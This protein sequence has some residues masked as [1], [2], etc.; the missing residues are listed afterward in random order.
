M[1][2]YPAPDPGPEPTATEEPF[3]CIQCARTHRF[4]FGHTV[5][6]A[7][8]SRD[9]QDGWRA[10]H[11]EPT[12]NKDPSAWGSFGLGP[13]P[14]SL[15]QEATANKDSS[16][17]HSK[18]F[19]CGDMCLTSRLYHREGH[20][21]CSES[22]SYAWGGDSDDATSRG[23]ASP[24]SQHPDASPNP[25]AP[26]S[27]LRYITANALGFLEGTVLVAL[28]RG[29]LLVAREHIELMIAEEEES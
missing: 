24:L 9:C 13:R 25:S 6:D 14:D 11:S 17:E 21:F 2:D 12:A 4:V 5:A 26:I 19:Y 27:P 20:G 16:D 15:D 1:T 3:R 10:V 29:D 8:C 18:C 7:F 23:A 28:S 22:C